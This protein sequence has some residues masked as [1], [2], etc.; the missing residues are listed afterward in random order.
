V[1]ECPIA[2]PIPTPA[3]VETMLD[4]IPPPWDCCAGGGAAAGA[5]AGGG[6][7][8]VRAGTEEVDAGRVC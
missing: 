6:G 2:C 1:R 4:I 5:W 8:D 7:W 3:A